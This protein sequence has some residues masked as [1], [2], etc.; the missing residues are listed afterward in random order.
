MLRSVTCKPRFSIY[1]ERD[2]EIRKKKGGGGNE[3][4]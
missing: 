3:Q 4:Q 1:K 2:L